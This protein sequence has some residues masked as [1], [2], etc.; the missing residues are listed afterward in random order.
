MVLV[1][2]RASSSHGFGGSA[3]SP[4]FGE[5]GGQPCCWLG[6]WVVD[7][8]VIGC[9]SCCSVRVALVGDSVMGCWGPKLVMLSH[10]PR[11]VLGPLRGVAAVPALTQS[12]HQMDRTF[13]LP[14]MTGISDSGTWQRRKR[15]GRS[16]IPRRPTSKTGKPC[17]TRTRFCAVPW[18][19][20]VTSLSA[21]SL[22]RPEVQMDGVGGYTFRP[23]V[24]ATQEA[25]CQ[26]EHEEL[27]L[28]QV[29]ST[30]TVYPVWLS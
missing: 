3:L 22:L 9:C 26:W 7:A 10:D 12:P 16:G 20:S 17:H 28:L 25:R 2:A 6:H 23:R 15:R 30:K 19:T 14:A 4:V 1:P 24:K 18:G 21:A 11:F 8:H 5:L 13:S 29:L 27:L